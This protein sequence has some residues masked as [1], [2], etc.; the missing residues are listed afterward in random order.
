[1]LCPD[2]LAIASTI[3]CTVYYAQICMFVQSSASPDYVDSL[4]GLGVLHH[5]WE[6]FFCPL[7]ATNNFSDCWLFSSV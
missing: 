4:L 5:F 1:M 3:L 6:H 7:V 2:V